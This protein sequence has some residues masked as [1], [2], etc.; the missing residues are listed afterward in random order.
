[1]ARRIARWAEKK[2]LNGVMGFGW[3]VNTGNPDCWAT[4][5]CFLYLAPW[6]ST[7]IPSPDSGSTQANHMALAVMA[8]VDRARTM[9][10]VDYKTS[11]RVRRPPLFTNH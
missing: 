8:G 11:T 7:G 4:P 6:G 9:R 2:T 5:E 3:T 10:C 1:M